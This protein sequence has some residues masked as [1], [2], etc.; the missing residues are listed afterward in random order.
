M[1]SSKLAKAFAVLS[2]GAV[3]F[4][5]FVMPV[6]AAS[7]EIELA[8]HTGTGEG[9]I[10]ATILYNNI[11]EDGTR[12]VLQFSGFNKVSKLPTKAA[13]KTN[14]IRW[15][16]LR[17]N[18]VDV[19]R[20]EDS[21][22]STTNAIDFVQFPLEFNNSNNAAVN[23]KL[24]PGSAKAGDTLGGDTNPDALLGVDQSTVTYDSPASLIGKETI[25]RIN[26]GTNKGSNQL[27]ITGTFELGQDTTG[28]NYV[29]SANGA[30][31]SKFTSADL[32]AHDYENLAISLSGS[33]SL[34]DVDNTAIVTDQTISTEAIITG[35]DS[36][37]GTGY[38]IDPG[39]LSNSEIITLRSSTSFVLKLT[40]LDTKGR[41]DAVPLYKKLDSNKTSDLL[42]WATINRDGT[43]IFDTPAVASYIYDKDYDMNP[44]SIELNTSEEFPF[45]KAIIV[46]DGV[47]ENT[48]YVAP[49][50]AAVPAPAGESTDAEPSEIDQASDDEAP[51]DEAPVEDNDEAGSED[52]ETGDEEGDDSA[53]ADDEGA[54]DA[55]IDAAPEVASKTGVAVA[56]IPAAIAAAAIVIS[57]KRK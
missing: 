46:A 29:S 21:I 57:R 43:A 7:A 17:V 6:S 10:N 50:G 42:G 53:N 16:S 31:S 51:A 2:A 54:D 28:A 47:G 26:T 27:V 40:G 25:A 11:G 1:K 55:T 48:D 52:D 33:Y 8:D 44:P 14:V 38:T 41:G 12:G 56:V 35:K 45:A 22:Y 30:A 4:G 15:K 3:A 24:T 23:L 37:T 39:R 20:T 49:N 34:A 5:T 19:L 32:D 18:G 9:Q 13:L 36:A